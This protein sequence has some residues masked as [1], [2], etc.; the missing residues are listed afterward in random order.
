MR[1]SGTQRR[2]SAAADLRQLHCLQA[3]PI[4]GADADRAHRQEVEQH[5][6]VHQRRHQPVRPLQG[7]RGD[8][9]QWY[10]VEFGRLQQQDLD[11]DHLRRRRQRGLR[12][13]GADV[14]LQRVHERLQRLELPRRR[15]GKVGD[16]VSANRQQR[17]GPGVLLAADRRPEPLAWHAPD[18]LGREAR[19]ADLG[20][21]RGYRGPRAAGHDS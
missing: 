6:A 2:R 16:H 21:R 7:H 13:D 4:P 1:H 8:T 15:P 5:T 17:R 14:A 3:A 18:L 12:R 19:L 20:L 10:V 9:G 11:A